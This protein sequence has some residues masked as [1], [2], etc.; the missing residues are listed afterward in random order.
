LEVGAL[1][2]SDLTPPASFPAR[3]PIPNSQFSIPNSQF[4]IPNPQPPTPN[5]QRV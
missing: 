2:S 3:T 5:L 1:R 4:L